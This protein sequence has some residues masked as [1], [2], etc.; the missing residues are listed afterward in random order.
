MAEWGGGHA[1]ASRRP[2]GRPATRLAHGDRPCGSGTARRQTDDGPDVA[3]TMRRHES[4]G[5][6][7][8][9]LPFLRKLGRLLGRDLIPKKPGPVAKKTKSGWR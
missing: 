5:R 9:D 2:V 3:P 1:T 4:T 8:G 6:A 7:L